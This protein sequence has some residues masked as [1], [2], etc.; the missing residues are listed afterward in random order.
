MIKSKISPSFDKNRQTLGK[1]FPL[2]SPFTVILD[3]S[4]RC[5]FRCQYCFR[6]NSDKKG[7]YYASRNDLM[8]MDVFR[9]AVD[10][11]MSF[12]TQPKS[13]SLSNHG[14]PLCNPNI[15]DMVKYLKSSGFLGNISIHTNGALMNEEYALKL[16]ESDID[17]IIFSIQGI[18][19]DNYKDMCGVN[20]NFN[21]LYRNIEILYR[22]RHHTR[23]DVK[24]VD[25]A[26]E[27][28]EDKKFYEIFSE[29]ADHVFIER[30]VP[31]WKNKDYNGLSS[32]SLEDN[33]NKYGVEI[34]KVECCRN[35]FDTIVVIPNGDV[36][37][38]TQ[39]AMEQKLGSILESSLVDLWDSPIRKKILIG[40]VSG[41]R[42]S[43][44]QNCYISKNSVFT[45]EDWI[46]PYKKEILERIMK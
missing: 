33:S 21:N 4:E 23:I 7:F 18:S 30:V 37:P 32:I 12:S 10:N 16:A 6:S 43:V 22:N 42:P 25:I 20:V 34:G 46:D 14:E 24:I 35:C 40:Q 3:A 15:A 28:G 31:I 1:I 13:I 9:L 17:R 19:S 11:V 29:I 26:L 41:S 36:Y 5:N 39:I 8:N 2:D 45:V 27:P 44:C 38:C